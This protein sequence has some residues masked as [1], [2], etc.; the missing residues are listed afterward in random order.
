MALELKSTSFKNGDFI[1]AEYTC[2]GK[3]ISPPLAW[4]DVPQTTKSF[5]IISDDPDAPIGTWVHWVIYD[6]PSDVR[7][8]PE[9]ISKVN[10]LSDGSKQGVNDFGKIGYGGP[11]PPPGS[12]HRY[13]F[14]LYA[15]NTKLELKPGLTKKA[16]ESAI[17]GHI[18]GEAELIGKFKR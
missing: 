12:A 3:D 5:A 8:L 17:K 13:F 7:H 14:K 1:P 9:N 16:L 4:N 10:I 11:C 15:L 6:I 18:A 2:K